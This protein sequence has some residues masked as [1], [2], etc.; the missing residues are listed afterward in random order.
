MLII[1]ATSHWLSF[2]LQV[3]VVII[4]ATSH[5]LSFRP[6]V[7]GYHSGYKSPVIIQGTS[8]FGYHSGYKS[9]VIT[10]ARSHW[11]SF[12]LQVTV[13]IFQATSHCGYH[14]GYKSLVITQATSHCGYHSGHKPL[15]IIQ[16]TSHWLSF[17]LQVTV[18]IIQATRHC[19]YHPGHKL[20]CF[21]FR[22]Q[23]Y[24]VTNITQASTYIS[25]Q[26]KNDLMPILNKMHRAMFTNSYFS[27]F[28]FLCFYIIILC[29][30]L[31][32]DDM[33]LCRLYRLVRRRGRIVAL[34]RLVCSNVN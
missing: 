3:T 29:I 12:R 31:T 26:F 23:V 9:L 33:V 34:P 17:R 28:T 10:Q 5:W 22:P 21:P 18:L 11:S 15:V 27:M 25:H 6:Q 14:S 16:A 24:I 2:R 19:V 30:F 20:P 13:R 32:V 1:Q 4:Q 8:H 7:T